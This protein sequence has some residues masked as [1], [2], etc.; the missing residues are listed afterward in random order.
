MCGP[1]DSVIGV[2]KDVIVATFRTARAIA[3]KIPEQGSMVVN[4]VAI[5]IDPK[6]KRATAIERVD[7]IVDISVH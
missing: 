7:R 5:D 1:R 4:A 6:T 2:D 3:H